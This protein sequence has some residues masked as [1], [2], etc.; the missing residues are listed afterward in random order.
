MTGASNFN[1]DIK[2]KDKSLLYKIIFK[3][4][5]QFRYNKYAPK[6]YFTNL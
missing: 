2:D 3:E 6:I 4:T 5:M 1:V